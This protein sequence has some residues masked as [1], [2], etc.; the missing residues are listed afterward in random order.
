MASVIDGNGHINACVSQRPVE[1]ITTF[2]G[3]ALFLY[4]TRNSAIGDKPRDAFRDINIRKI[5]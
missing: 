5:S 1:I 4:T 3:G 2:A